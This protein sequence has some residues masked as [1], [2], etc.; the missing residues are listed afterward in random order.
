[1]NSDKK[2]LEFQY[3]NYIYP[4]PVED[5][6]EEII[7]IGKVPYADPNFSWHILWPEKKY[8]FKGLNIL[9]AG[10][11]SDQASILAKCNP[12][13][14]F[15]GIDLS[16]SSINHQKKLIIK[17]SIKNLNLICDD[18]REVVFKNKFDYI[19]STGVI[20]HLIDPESGL[21][22]FYENLREEGVIYLM[23][24]GDKM[25]QSLN[26]LKKVFNNLSL[27][28]DK[29]SINLVKETIKNLNSKHPT[30]IFTNDTDDIKYD[31]GIIDL[32]LHRQ[33]KFY[34]IKELLN[35]LNKNN[36]IIKNFFDGKISSVTK[37]FL[38][39]VKIINQIRNLSIDSKLEMGQI[40]NWDD[41]KIE[42][43]IC[44]K[45]NK[46]NS[47]VYNKINILLCYIHPNRGLKYRIIKN[48]IEIK[49]NFSNKIFVYETPNKIDFNWKVILSG[50]TKINEIFINNNE[51]E[52]E[53]IL[54]FFENI[55]ENHHLDISLYPIG[56]YI[57][58]FAK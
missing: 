36:L 33:E 57:D 47:L 3:N 40:L 17:H 49:E 12:G 13:H 14:K 5:I 24:Y 11:G 6:D 10:C 35:I 45:N 50:Q 54:S 56:K 42:L 28:Q 15:T 18:F 34:S 32:V 26:E 53:V 1:M 29:E 48:A 9:I 21:K 8:K 39:N 38:N 31:A 4:K 55:I 20:H 16:K 44:K 30:K 27:K 41:R 43:V 58:H 22:Y 25:S 51:K 37:F 19:I 2:N 52:L 46:I 23:V 7:K